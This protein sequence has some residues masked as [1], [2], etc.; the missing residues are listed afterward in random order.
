LCS[1]GAA[2]G[3][4]AFINYDLALVIEEVVVRLGASRHQP[5]L[6][7]FAGR[8]GAPGA[9]SINACPFPR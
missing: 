1:T 4:S 6:E 2:L 5:K 8:R 7:L 9:I 3:I